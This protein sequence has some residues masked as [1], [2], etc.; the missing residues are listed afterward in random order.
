MVTKDRVVRLIA[1]VLAVAFFWIAVQAFRADNHTA[2][3]QMHRDGQGGT[4][5]VGEDVK[6]PGPDRERG[7]IFIILGALAAYYALSKKDNE[8][9]DVTSSV[10]IMKFDIE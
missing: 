10:I 5:C 2:C 7:I 6:A 3:T 4:E 8:P 9:E 1:V